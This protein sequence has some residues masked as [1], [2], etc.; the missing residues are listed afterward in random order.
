MVWPF[1]D[2]VRGQGHIMLR[3]ENIVTM[4]WN[5]DFKLG[6]SM[7]DMEYL[8]QWIFK[9]QKVKVSVNLLHFVHVFLRSL[10]TSIFNLLTLYLLWTACLLKWTL[11]FH[12]WIRWYTN[13]ADH[14]S[15]TPLNASCRAHVQLKYQ[16]TSKLFAIVWLRVHKANT[17]AQHII[18]FQMTCCL[19]FQLYTSSAAGIQRSI[20]FMVSWVSHSLIITWGKLGHIYV[21]AFLALGHQWCNVAMVALKGSCSL[22]VGH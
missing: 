16:T 15:N 14:E 9:K 2:Q 6:A 11:S 20:T 10:V 21:W 5:A 13:S 19:T 12:Y 1:I 17:I 22:H 4:K 7:N 8:E 18:Y 3:A